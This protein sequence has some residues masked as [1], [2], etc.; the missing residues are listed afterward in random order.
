MVDTRNTRINRR[1]VMLTVSVRLLDKIVKSH[2][3]KVMV[4]KVI[5]QNNIL[6]SIVNM[7]MMALPV[8]AD[9]GAF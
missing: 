4:T 8:E 5:I 6:G 2:V 3:G 9:A 1:V 7:A